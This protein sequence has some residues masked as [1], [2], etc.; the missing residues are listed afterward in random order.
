MYI[1][2]TAILVQDRSHRIIRTRSEQGLSGGRER[3]VYRLRWDRLM[4]VKTLDRGAWTGSLLELRG[5]KI[6]S[7]L[8][9]KREYPSPQT[10]WLRSVTD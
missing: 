3:A 6:Q 8:E 7:G 9:L 4:K 2:G 10:R 1:L 5:R